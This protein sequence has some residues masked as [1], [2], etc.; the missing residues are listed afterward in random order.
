MNILGA[1]KAK[2]DLYFLADQTGSMYNAMENVKANIVAGYKTFMGDNPKWDVQIGI[3]AYKDVDDGSGLFKN[4]QAITSNQV[5]IQTAANT[6]VA[7]GGGDTDEAQAYALTWIA[8]NRAQIGWRPASNRI[9]IWFGDEPGHDPVQYPPSTGP[10]Y[11]FID[12]T[13]ALIHNNVRVFAFSVAPS[14]NLDKRIVPGQTCGQATYV[15]NLTN[16]VTDGS[17]LMSNVEQAGVIPFI[18]NNL[19]TEIPS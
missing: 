6:L 13:A 15:T 7:D 5:A 1:R 8:Q 10:E 19:E 11:S 17:Y 14:N 16:G 2:V 18:F 12:A 4:L 3:G 9:V